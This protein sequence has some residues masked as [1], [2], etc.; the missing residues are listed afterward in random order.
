MNRL[1]VAA[2]VLGL[3]ALA[4][5]ARAATATANLAVNATVTRT[6]SIA[7]ATL[8]FPDYDPSLGVGLTSQALT[9]KCNKGYVPT[10]AIGNGAN[11]SGTRRMANGGDF[12]AYNLALRSGAAT[13]DSI[14]PAAATDATG[15]VGVSVEGSIPA[16]QWV[17]ANVTPYSDVVVMTV[18]F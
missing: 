7:A 14:T 12:L 17:P 2:A 15:V 18:T 10:I 11:Y 13:G 1:A 9:V 4:A 3:T 5:P 8:A 6:C 16:N